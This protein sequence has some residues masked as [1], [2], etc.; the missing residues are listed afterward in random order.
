MSVALEPFGDAA[1]R[2]RLPEG[3]AARAVFESLRA[4]PGVIDAVVTERHAL[5]TFD[6]PR[7]RR[8]SC[9]AIAARAVGAGAGRR[10]LEE[11]A[12]ARALRRVRTS[13]TCRAPPAGTRRGGHRAAHARARTSSP[14]SA[15]CPASRTSAGST[16]G[17][18][19]PAARRRARASRAGGRNRRAVHGR[20]PARVPRGMAPARNGGRGRALRPSLGGDARPRGSRHVRGGAV[21]RIVAV[22]GLATVQDARAPRT[23][24]RGRPARG[25]AR[26][27]ASR[28]RERGGAQRLGRGRHRGLRRR[29][30]WRERAGVRRDRRGGGGDGSRRRGRGRSPAAG[31]RV[32]YVAVRGGHRRA[33]TSSAAGARCSPAASAGT[34]GRPLRRGDA[35]RAGGPAGPAR[36]RRAERRRRRPAIRAR[37][38]PRI[39]VVPG[40][41]L[42]RFA[43]GRARR[44]PRLALRDCRAERPRRSASAR[45]G[46]ASR[47]RRRGGLG[48]HGPRGHPGARPPASPSSSDRITRPQAAT[49][50][51]RPSSAPTSGRSCSPAG[52]PRCVSAWADVRWNRDHDGRS[53]AANDLRAGRRLPRHRTGYSETRGPT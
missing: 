14:R 47:R 9:D 7:P 48:A 20:L 5:V 42:E 16:P 36:R 23:D 30:P 26:R 29:S 12:I 41:D 28:E 35:L 52:R 8:G 31:A 53:G 24:A 45:A 2:A 37:R 46:P 10:R 43:P 32:R 13:T 50:S 19:C 21:I 51:W 40:P 44:P 15:S 34:K 6:L 18:S 27:R 1:L 25:R 11:H 39:R 38:R 3:A 17:S 4:L 33:R 22:A 49:P